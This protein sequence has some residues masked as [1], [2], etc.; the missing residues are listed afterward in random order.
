MCTSAHLL[1]DLIA[2]GHKAGALWIRTAGPMVHPHRTRTMR[3]PLGGA[4]IFMDP[5]SG[6]IAD[7]M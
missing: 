4:I 3:P 1:N 7:S 2:T 6:L 5:S